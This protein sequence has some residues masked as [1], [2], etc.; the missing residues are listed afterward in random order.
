MNYHF[1]AIALIL[2]VK[3]LR[4]LHHVFF[5]NLAICDFGVM[6]MDV[7][8]LLGATFGK[9]FYMDRPIL[10]EISGF[11]CMMSCFGSLWTMMFIAINRLVLFKLLS[12]LVRYI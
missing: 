9:G 8:V 4:Q 1:S 11:V 7:F 2:F 5:I 3:E 10:C 12:F 6:V